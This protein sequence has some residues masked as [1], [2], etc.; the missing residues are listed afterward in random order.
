[1]WQNA[2]AIGDQDKWSNCFYVGQNLIP[3]AF[4]SKKRIELE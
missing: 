1:M 3:K 2:K 4:N